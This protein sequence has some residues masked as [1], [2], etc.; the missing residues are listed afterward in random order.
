[1]RHLARV[2]LGV[3]ALVLGLA[4]ASPAGATVYLS[5]SGNDGA[6]CT[7]AA[8]CRS[9]DRGFRAAPAGTDVEMAGG[10]Y[11]SQTLAGEPAKGA[12]VT[13]HPAAG[14]TVTLGYLSIEGTSNVEVQSVNTNGWGIT[15]G[16]AHVVLRNVRATDVTSGA[17]A[18]FSGADDVQ[19]IGG[20]IAR[21]DP[22]DG[23]HMNNGYGTN[24]NITIDGLFEHDLTRNRDSSSHDDCLQAGDVTNL[25][26]RNSRFFNCGT[27]GIFLNPYNGGVTKNVTLENNWFGK[28]QLGYNIVYVGEAQGVSMRNNSFTGS[29]YV[30]PDA[31]SGVTMVD[32]ILDLDAYTCQ[33]TAAASDVFDFNMSTNGCSGAKH[34]TVNAKL[35]SQFVNAAPGDATGFD[36]HL[37]AGAAAIDKGSP[38]DSA[39]TDIDGQRRPI[40]GAPDAGADEFGTDPA[41]A[42][43]AAAPAPA[44][45]PPA[46]AKPASSALSRVLA[47]LSAKT[48]K[49][50][51]G[52]EHKRLGT[53]AP[54]TLAGVDDE[55]ICHAARRGCPS[56]TR[57]HIVLSRA[58]K[59]RVTFRKV[60]ANRRAARVRVS[61]RTLRQ[62]AGSLRIRA[63]GLGKGRYHLVVRTANGATADVVLRIA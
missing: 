22:E 50:I 34:H 14:A 40:G 13:F 57:L 45:A 47:G 32:N 17:A 53:H 19:I 9:M 6:A 36:L 59:L 20:E 44:P 18:Y 29:M 24:S 60:R 16:S 3:P 63:R 38:T 8:P 30:D 39:A 55:R 62:G 51:A 12:N 5:P 35:M 25:T 11:G 54:L 43:A 52:V 7:A 42:P 46:V 41:Q 23:I 2:G 28:A 31:S 4:F 27:Q 21:V 61:T 56:S 15:R 1:M 48:L 49:A 26:I 33:S 58:T 10:S 37:K